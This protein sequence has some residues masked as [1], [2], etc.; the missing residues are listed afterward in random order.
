M[1]PQET[2]TLRDGFRL[3]FRISGNGPP[4]MLL[5][6]FTGSL[7]AWPE[8][9]VS[10]LSATRTVLRVDLHG[11][12]DS[13]DPLGPERVEMSR[14]VD[15]LLE[16][17]DFLELPQF[18]LAGY[19]MGGRVA[20]ALAVLAP[21]RLRTLTLESASPGLATR[22]ERERRILEDQT[23]AA[24]LHRDGIEAFVDGWM[25]MP[26]FSTQA[27]RLTPA[28]LQAEQTRRLGNRAAALAHVL[29]GMGTGSQPSLWSRLDRV[30][31]PVLLVAGT[32]DAKFLGL[33]KDM[34]ARFPD[35][36]LAPIQGVGH[37]VHL[38]DPDAWIAAVTG[39]LDHI[40]SGSSGH[41]KSLRT[42]R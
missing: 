20:L 25:R 34:S 13:S 18:D 40:E 4:L 41:D 27:Q 17:V 2:L 19:S 12:G 29:V 36:V 33:A 7:A 21:E 3:A 42:S 32:L 15:D 1:A 8:P 16:L 14:V 39:F 24:A 30:T 31:V 35:A 10:Q 11:H 37:A 23:R 6:G 9:L 5:H 22:E 28:V 38:E 26:L